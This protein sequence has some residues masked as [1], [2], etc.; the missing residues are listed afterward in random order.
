MEEISLTLEWRHCL[1]GEKLDSI[2]E[3]IRE[4]GGIYLWLYRNP[5]YGVHYIGET[6]SF[7]SRF[8]THISSI[9]SGFY[10]AFNTEELEKLDREGFVR[11]LN[12]Y[13]E[14][15]RGGD[16]FYTPDPES[17]ASIFFN[18][19]WAPRQRRYLENILFAFATLE[20]VYPPL[21]HETDMPLLRKEIEAALI[22]SYKRKLGLHRKAPI[23]NHSRLPSVNYSIRHEGEALDMIPDEI[24]EIRSWSK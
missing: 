24:L 19:V 7:L 14:G 6:N 10:T 1:P 23:G 9:L 12:R 16:L 4:Y 18:P 13:A 8:T 15:A 11:E 17:L 2:K 20:E 3:F 21:D 22:I 5:P